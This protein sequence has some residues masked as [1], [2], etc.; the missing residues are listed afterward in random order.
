MAAM[1]LMTSARFS[2]AEPKTRANGSEA[3]FAACGKTCAPDCRTAMLADGR[4][5]PACNYASCCYDGADY[6]VWMLD[7]LT[8]AQRLL[9]L[10]TDDAAQ[11]AVRVLGDVCNLERVYSRDAAFG[12][13]LQRL[14]VVA[15]CRL[16][17]SL[18]SGSDITGIQVPSIIL[19]SRSGFQTAIE[20]HLAALQGL[21][22]AMENATSTALGH[23]QMLQQY[24]HRTA[25]DPTQ[26]AALQPTYLG[27]TLDR[28]DKILQDQL[29]AMVAAT[30][31]NDLVGAVLQLG[32]RD[33][34]LLLT[35]TDL[36]GSQAKQLLNRVLRTSAIQEALLTSPLGLLL[37]PEGKL[38]PDGKSS[39]SFSILDEW[40]NGDLTLC[41]QQPDGGNTKTLL[42][43][44]PVRPS[45]K[46]ASSSSSNASSTI[47][48]HF[49]NIALGTD[50]KTGAFLFVLRGVPS[51]KRVANPLPRHQIKDDSFTEYRGHYMVHK[52]SG[53]V[54]LPGGDR[55]LLQGM[56]LEEVLMDKAAAGPKS[57]NGISKLLNS[58][59]KSVLL[60]D[61]WDADGDGFVRVDELWTFLNQAALVS[62][63][64][65]SIWDAWR[66]SMF[67]GVG[68]NTDLNVT[69]G[70][71]LDGYFHP[72]NVSYAAVEAVSA[73]LRKSVGAADGITHSFW[74]IHMWDAD[75]DGRISQGD[76]LRTMAYMGTLK[77]DGK[78]LVTHYYSAS[79]ATV[80]GTVTDAGSVLATC[81]G[82]ALGGLRGGWLGIV[83]GAFTCGGAIARAYIP[84]PVG[85]A[86]GFIASTIGTAINI[87]TAPARIIA[88]AVW[89]GLK[90]V[91]SAI[92]KG[93]KKLF[94]WLGRRSLAE[95]AYSPCSIGGDSGDSNNSDSQLLG[96]LLMSGEGGGNKGSSG[97]F[98]WLMTNEHFNSE[99]DKDDGSGGN[100]F[101]AFAL[102]DNGNWQ[103]DSSDNVSSSSDLTSSSDGT[104]AAIGGSSTSGLR[105]VLFGGNS[106]S[107]SSSSDDDYGSGIVNSLY[108][109]SVNTDYSSSNVAQRELEQH[110]TAAATGAARSS[111]ATL[112]SS[113]S[114]TSSW[115]SSGHGM[116][117]ASTIS[118]R[119]RILLPQR[120]QRHER[121][122][123]QQAA[124]ATGDAAA[125]HENELEAMLQMYDE[126]LN[127]I[128]RVAQVG[129]NGMAYKAQPSVAR[130][131]AVMKSFLLSNSVP[132]KQSFESQP[133]LSAVLGL[134]DEQGMMMVVNMEENSQ[135][136]AGGMAMMKASQS[137]T[138]DSAEDMGVSA[139]GGGHQSWMTERWWGSMESRTQDATGSRRSIQEA[140]VS[141]DPY[142]GPDV[143]PPAIALSDIDREVSG[144]SAAGR[145][146]D[147]LFQ[148]L[149]PL[150]GPSF[151]GM[152]RGL[153]AMSR[154]MWEALDAVSG[155]QQVRNW[156]D[157]YLEL[158]NTVADSPA[159]CAASDL[160]S[161]FGDTQDN[162]SQWAAAATLRGRGG[163]VLLKMYHSLLQ[164]HLI[165]QLRRLA[166]QYEMSTG[167]PSKLLQ[168]LD[169]LMIN[170]TALAPSDPTAGVLRKV[171]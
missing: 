137:S 94:S 71:L 79:T 109:Y 143:P 31:E 88:Q 170:L 96:E 147:K 44:A 160:S 132:L 165:R 82:A 34:T 19:E 25:N 70:G 18:Y 135:Q 169:S 104:G 40:T 52:P 65:N 87:I 97:L 23:I 33:T 49:V 154:L 148:L 120:P 22:D 99:A 107:S 139:G 53:M 161:T 124:A 80:A 155:A 85:K 157:L 108:D 167:S 16:Q 90:A 51:P 48:A 11:E 73:L 112:G 74:G 144:E 131:S 133:S 92:V 26:W 2:S 102:S 3:L 21:E 123:L 12:D 100:G 134:T 163:L 75:A 45:T 91:G 42:V 140:G 95:G 127:E 152:G 24:F 110:L 77:E 58:M 115:S 106:S 118:T 129:F 98:S 171:R 67:E 142:L 117:T 46:L 119:E 29:A 69:R 162:P 121:R 38:F 166:L 63:L 32:L 164:T 93:F 150:V 149:Q 101:F 1:E 156:L 83:G 128:Q 151:E 62:D 125:V 60:G 14:L 35:A 61:A 41:R 64:G 145:P 89:T 126:T 28:G 50:N 47:Y 37:M 122:R 103:N 6:E 39:T 111:S 105:N 84:G 54:L 153:A 168:Q 158:L 130:H 81:A 159:V 17:L 114:S 7:K 55:V 10:N 8:S 76:V 56:S 136:V 13:K 68:S 5:D 43:T 30:R 4:L 36:Q 20:Q 116:M 66:Q 78:K 141:S 59:G 72:E 138:A 86:I 146:D 113:Y 27:S 9:L 57:L 15:A